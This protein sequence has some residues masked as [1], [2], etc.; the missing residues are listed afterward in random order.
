MATIKRGRVLR[1]TSTGE[2]LVFV[3]GNQYPF[4]LEGMWRSEFAP[5]ANMAVD[6]EFDDQG[7]IVALRS[8]AGSTAAGEQASQAL[9]AAGA[10]AKKMATEFQSKGLPV[11]QEWAKAVGYNKLIAFAALVIAWFWL[12]A[13]S[14][15]MGF[16]GN[17]SITFYESLKFLNSGGMAMGG[18]GAGIYGFLVLIALVGVV[19][20]QF[21]KDP[22]A[23]YGMCLPLLLM[24]LV[25][26][27]AYFK[28]SSQMS[29]AEDAMGQFGNDPQY[30]EMAKNMASEARKQMWAAFSFGFG[31]YVASAASA[32]LAWLGWTSARGGSSAPQL[33]TA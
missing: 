26:L 32:Y 28:A 13:F 21:W 12:P 30:Q 24:G 29:D 17:G 27:I 16:L 22:R 15:K 25:F 7:K 3:D 10:A 20:H 6:V 9:D 8:V 31:L 4:K 5:K 14:I 23:G 2:G 18:G 1:D 19:A 11:I 33:Q